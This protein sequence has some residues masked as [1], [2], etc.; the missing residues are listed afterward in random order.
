MYNVESKNGF[1]P[2]TKQLRGDTFE[3]F[4]LE[5]DSNYFGVSSAKA[6]LKDK[7][8]EKEIEILKNYLSNFQCVTI[9]N[10]NNDSYNNIWLSK[11]SN[12]LLT[13]INVQFIKN[14]KNSDIDNIDDTS[15]VVEAPLRNQRILEISSKAFK[16]SRFFN[17]PWLPK[18]K[19]RDIYT[20]WTENAFNKKGKFFAIS[21]RENEIAGFLLF[22]INSDDS[23]GTIE[24]VAT[25]DTYK[26]QGVGTSLII[27]MES[28]MHEKGISSIKVGTQINNASAMRFYNARGYKYSSSYTVY[29][30]WPNK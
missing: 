11:D 27:A 3:A 22:S 26:G 8:P 14:L 28:F 13:D 10:I 21:K 30:Y 5:W 7:V 23:Q 24:L 25:D 1:E 29:H 2:Y 17:D 9:T 20:I 12:I 6:I 4:E 16:Y 15:Y 19:A 18:D